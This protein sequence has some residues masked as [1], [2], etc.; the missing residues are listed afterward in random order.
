MPETQDAKAAASSEHSNVT[1]A[2]ADGRFKAIGGSVPVF[3]KV[4]VADELLDGSVG[5]P[6]ILV[7]GGSVSNTHE[8]VAGV[9]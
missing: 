9:L 1:S 8:N 6:V 4:N 5:L 2:G 3:V 7:S